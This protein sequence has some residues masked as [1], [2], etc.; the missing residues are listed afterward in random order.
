MVLVV[1]GALSLSEWWIQHVQRGLGSKDMVCEYLSGRRSLEHEL[2]D[3]ILHFL[4]L[5]LIVD[6]T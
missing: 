5:L 2:I 4:Q 6:V 1:L 3:Y